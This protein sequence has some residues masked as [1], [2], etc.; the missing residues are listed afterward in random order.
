MAC[1]CSPVAAIRLLF[2]RIYPLLGAHLTPEHVFKIL[3]LNCYSPS[4]QQPRGL[5][6]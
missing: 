4:A 5:G 6:F 2:G 1:D 3:L